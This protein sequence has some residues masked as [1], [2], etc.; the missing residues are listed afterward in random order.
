MGTLSPFHSGALTTNL[1]ACALAARADGFEA[2]VLARRSPHPP[3]QDVSARFVAFPEPK[4][5]VSTLAAR[6]ERK[7]WGWPHLGQRRYAMRVARALSASQFQGVPWIISNDPDLAVY[8]RARFPTAFLVHRFH[9]QMAAN[10]RVKAKLASSIN[11]CVAVSD[12]TRDW[13]ENY[14][15]FAPGAVQTVYNGVDSSQFSPA[16][17]EAAGPPVLN[18]VGRTGIEKGADILLDAALILARQT[19]RPP[20]S[21]QIVGANHWTGFQLDPYQTKLLERVEALE[22]LGVAVRRPGHVNRGD[23]PAEFR[24]AHIHVVPSRWDEPFG[25]TTVE[26]MASGLA[27]VASHTGGSPEIIADAGFLFERD[28]PQDLASKLLPLI[29]NP[30]LRRDYAARARE[31]A[32]VFSWDNTWKG[33]KRAARLES[34]RE[35]PR[36]QTKN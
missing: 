23:V 28:N 4:N 33:L 19:P 26:G 13:V 17:S 25:L 18:F 5:R 16:T 30:E 8:L 24:R 22:K 21:L 20:F 15:G 34:R 32:L 35:E 31:R 2:L 3:Y 7:I 10:S 27:T 6:L 12:F 14:Y 29:E 1:R 11:A 36:V 9:N